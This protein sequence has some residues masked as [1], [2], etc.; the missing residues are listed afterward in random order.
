MKKKL[1]IIIGP[2]A[3][4]K[5]KLA[6]ILAERLNGSVI[7]GDAFQIYKEIN[8]GVNKPT[9]EELKKIDYYMINEISYKDEWSIA[10]FQTKFNQ[11]YDDIVHKNKM[12]ILC[13]G[14]HLYTDCII[15]GYDLNNDTSKFEKEIED[16]DINQLYQYVQKYDPISAEKIGP[17]NFKR[18]HRCVVILKA[19]DNKP[20]SETD[21]LKNKPIYDCL[22][23]MVNKD[24]AIL[25]DKINKRFDEM[26]SNNKWINEVQQ[27]INDN[28]EIINSLAFKAIGYTEIAN[29][30]I[31]KTPIDTEKLKQKTRQLAKR[32]LTWCNNKFD[33]KIVFDF[34]KDNLENLIEEVKHFYYD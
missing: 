10:H 16:W 31:N 32:Q 2:T 14:S 26:F 25:Y 20:K 8:V 11:Y 12:P 23:I 17:N 28:P 13:G 7:N 29:S 19:N 9:E 18:L 21:L 1:I 30:L 4:K 34:D 27:L 33:E 6:H 24:K 5:S 15:H 3:A 22:I